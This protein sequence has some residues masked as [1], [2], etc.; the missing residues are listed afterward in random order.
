MSM[1]KTTALLAA[2][3]MFVSVSAAS[4][5]N[6]LSVTSELNGKYTDGN[7]IHLFTLT[8]KNGMIAKL[9]EVGG[10]LITLEVPDRDGKVAKIKLEN[11]PMFARGGFM[12][13]GVIGR[14]ANRVSGAQFTLDGNTYQLTRN[15]GRN[16]LHD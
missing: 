1:A 4:E 13:G 11:Q 3:I 5:S 14:V 16:Q 10:A 15:E 8:N 6:G 7:D 2:L 9:N 12:N